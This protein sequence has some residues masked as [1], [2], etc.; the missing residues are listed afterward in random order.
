[1][2][3]E[4]K[5]VAPAGIEASWDFDADRRSSVTEWV[6]TEV[7]RHSTIWPARIWTVSGWKL[8]KPMST[9]ADAFGEAGP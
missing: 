2:S 8:E 9:T 6:M 5:G 1:M 4:L 3:P 7:L